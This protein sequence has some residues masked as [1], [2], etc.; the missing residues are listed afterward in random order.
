MR[1]RCRYF[2]GLL[3]TVFAIGACESSNESFV[4]GLAL[5]E[6]TVLPTLSTLDL[7][8]ISPASDPSYFEL[9]HGAQVPPEEAIGSSGELCSQASNKPI[10]EQEFSLM[11]TSDA[12]EGVC[13][14]DGCTS[15]IL[16]NQG[17]DNRFFIGTSGFV[18][19]FGPVDS[20]EEAAMI[21]ATKGYEWDSIELSEGG[22]RQVEDGYQLLVQKLD[23]SSC[24]PSLMRRYLLHVGTDA[25]VT[26]LE[27]EFLREI[28]GCP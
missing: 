4:D 15:F 11:R 2:F 18:E 20:F 10:C 24:S 22:Y 17:S 12:F 14:A 21:V 19:L 26:V 7:S 8:K 5:D 1:Q 6:F 23:L 3:A 25:T 9:W 16:S 28:S 27:D 13:D